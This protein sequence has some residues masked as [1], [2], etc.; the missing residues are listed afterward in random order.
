MPSEFPKLLVSDNAGK[1]YDIPYLQ[2]AGMESGVPF[3]LRPSDLTE[4][5]PDSELFMLPERS[6]VGFDPDRGS[7]VE[8]A[9]DFLPAGKE[10]CNAV[11]AFLAPGYTATFSASYKERGNPDPLPLFSYAAAA[12]FK[13]RVFAAGVRVDMERRQALSGMDPEK[14]KKGVKETR[15]LFPRNRLMRHLE[16]CALIYCCPAARN[17]FLKRYEAP[18]PT[19]PYCNA[20]CAG[21]I[22]YQPR[23]GHPVTQPRIEFV[24]T[25]EE[26]AQTA[27]YHISNVKD[28]VVSFGQGCEGEPLM[29]GD[30]IVRSLKMIRKATRKGIINMNTNASKPRMISRLFDE[31]LDS[32]RV[33]MNSARKKFYD[34]YYR[35]GGYSLKDVE[36]SIMAAKRSGGFVSVNY[37]V[38]PGFTDSLD[39]IQAFR[40]LIDRTGIDMI[41]WRN[42]NYDPRA[43]CRVMGVKAKSDE[44]TGMSGL[45]KEIKR[46]YPGIMHGYFNPAKGKIKRF[47]VRDI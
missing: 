36:S 42:L 17:F 10:G 22:S 31:G 47:R 11:A 40:S 13:G 18:L 35:P 3:C 44:I 4:I 46:E 8:L 41:Q 28:P 43:Y 29:V 34:L 26:I 14:I 15:G 19:A 23:K 45:I 24:P 25:P 30:T 9:P 32:M 1:I 16:K 6:P 7:F 38:M 12:F 33:S 27:L 21:C 37:L 2:A 39:E 5:H 20:S